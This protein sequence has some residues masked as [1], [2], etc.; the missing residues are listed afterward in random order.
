MV[1]LALAAALAAATPQSAPP[2][3]PP[4]PSA[5]SPAMFEVRD[6]DTAFYIF[7]TFHALDGQSEWFS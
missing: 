1:N 3:L 4:A 6:A 2:A 7:G 5:P